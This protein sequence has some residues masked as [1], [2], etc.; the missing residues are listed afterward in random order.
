MKK[1]N[2]KRLIAAIVA[3]TSLTAFCG[4]AVTA[5]AREKETTIV[6]DDFS[7]DTYTDSVNSANWETYTSQTEE[8]TVA[9][10]KS[11]NA[12]LKFIKKRSDGGQVAAYT[13]AKYVMKS[14]QFDFFMEE[15]FDNWLGF[16][17]VSSIPA[18][19]IPSIYGSPI[20]F[21]GKEFSPNGVDI[22]SGNNKYANALGETYSNTKNYNGEWLTVK[23]VFNLDKTNEFTLW[24]GRQ[25]TTLAQAMTV[26]AKNA[27]RVFNEGYLRLGVNNSKGGSVH[28]DN[29]VIETTVKNQTQEGGDTVVTW[30][31]GEVITED[32]ENGKGIF[33]IKNDGSQR[34]VRAQVSS[35]SGL[36]FTEAAKGD[37]VVAK[38]A[39]VVDDGLLA[40]L[41]GLD[42]SFNAKVVE[43]GSLLAFAFG[44]KKKTTEPFSIGTYA[45]VFSNQDAKII[46][47]VE[48]GDNVEEEEIGK[49]NL[50]NISDAEVGSNINITFNKNGE[51]VVT[52]R[53]VEGSNG[54]FSDVSAKFDL[55]GGVYAGYVA[56]A[57]AADATYAQVGEVEILNT[58]YTVPVTKSLTHNFSTD[59][60]GNEEKPDFVMS[61]IP[62]NTMSVKDGRLNFNGC[63][64]GSIFA[65][66]YQYDDF[67]LDYKI[68]D[69]YVGEEGAKDDEATASGRW[70]GLDIGRE[71][72]G[73]TSY[74][75]YLMFYF[76]ITP[77]GEYTTLTEY[78]ANDGD[79]PEKLEIT[80]IDGKG[81]PSSLF[82]DI[83]YT[84][85]IS[86]VKP[87]DAVCVRWVSEDNSLKLYMKKASDKKFVHYY[88]VEGV[89]T[90]GHVALCC[91][92]YT[93]CN[94]DDFSIANTSP[95]FEC[96]DN[97]YPETIIKEVE[98]EYDY[99][100]Y[101]FDINFDEEKNYL[102]DKDRYVSADGC[103]GSTGSSLFG[104]ASILA[105][106]VVFNKNGKR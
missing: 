2:K 86:S 3:A 41:V 91:T 38:I 23:Y 37:R 104:I 106:L 80:P 96:G 53:D 83:Q 100:K 47:Y 60:L 21:T 81:I 93:Y 12:T 57:S 69:I 79:T 75:S 105:L 66:A 62:A 84:N 95:I 17:I 10:L 71:N 13:S 35:G 7:N 99:N 9:Q 6:K 51:L 45:I 14:V 98:P 68:T 22:I 16:D 27:S 87:G 64:D 65:P 15:G 1:N 97:D 19:G 46:K 20:L 94:I 92:G 28:Y 82:N 32:F 55:G 42:V 11:D 103:S 76:R 52:E 58:T 88:T 4:S 72:Y 30:T 70:L 29:V 8:N 24:F 49:V 44:L 40:S 78:K 50:A 34:K 63:S 5:F 54:N 26:T 33:E 77:D 25:G 101:I 74:G 89:E 56:F 36:G 31:D 90:S 48:D 85:D 43:D 67:I 39:S 61:S 73:T 18:S 102:T 59:Y